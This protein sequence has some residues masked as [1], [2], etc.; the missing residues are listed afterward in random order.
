MST[1]YPNIGRSKR[2][3]TLDAA[4][5][6][7][8]AE[9]MVV[10]QNQ[11]ARRTTVTDVR[12]SSSG[13]TASRPTLTSADEGFCY[14]DTTLQIPIWWSGSAWKTAAGVAA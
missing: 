1:A 9:L 7:T 2:I 12:K 10:V 5:A 13:T 4:S 8:G 3:S 6:L 14:Y 11:T